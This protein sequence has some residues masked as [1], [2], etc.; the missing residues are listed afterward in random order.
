MS[1]EFPDVVGRGTGSNL[2]LQDLLR[3]LLNCYCFESLTNDKVMGTKYMSRRC[4]HLHF[5]SVAFHTYL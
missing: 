1:E 2:D 5:N 4:I 3:P